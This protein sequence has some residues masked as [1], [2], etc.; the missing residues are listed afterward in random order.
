[1][2][3][4]GPTCGLDDKGPPTEGK[5]GVSLEFGGVARAATGGVALATLPEGDWAKFGVTARATFGGVSRDAAIGDAVGAEDCCRGTPALAAAGITGTGGEL[6]AGGWLS[7]E[8]VGESCNMGC[9]SK[10]GKI[11]VAKSGSTVD[12]VA[13]GVDTGGRVVTG[14]G[15]P[16]FTVCITDSDGCS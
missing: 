6:T 4:G 10:E 15:V 9:P 2:E 16:W 3:T 13:M 7:F 5:G 1:M 14:G 11:C 8:D 12:N